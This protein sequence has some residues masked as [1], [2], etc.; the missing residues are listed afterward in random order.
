MPIYTGSHPIKGVY[1][2]SHPIKEVYAGSRLVWAAKTWDWIDDFERAS[3]GTAWTGS[4]ALIT[5]T[6]PNRYLRKNTAAGSA[7]LWTAQQFSTDDIEVEAVLGPVPDAQQRAAIM[8]GSSAQNIYVEFGQQFGIIGD[9]NGSAWTTRT[10]FGGRT[11]AQG[12]IINVRR[13][14]NTITVS[15]NGS[16]IATATS[17]VAK[18]TNFRRVALS[19]KMAVN[20]FAFYGPGFDT[21]KIAS[22]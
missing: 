2:G 16:E 21:V 9:Y 17:T 10:T 13:S 14:F 20:I 7:D 15:R 22:I 1:A 11:W 4:G 18:G 5:G 6:A 19:V 3:I 8:L 12:D